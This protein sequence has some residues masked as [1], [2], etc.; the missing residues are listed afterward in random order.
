[1]ARQ[2]SRTVKLTPHEL[3]IKDTRPTFLLLIK[4][5]LTEIEVQKI[6]IRLL[7]L[8]EPLQQLR[9]EQMHFDILRQARHVFR[10][11]D[12]FVLDD[13]E[14]AEGFAV[15]PVGAQRGVGGR[16]GAALTDLA[17][18]RLRVE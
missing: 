11:N 15:G 10:H 4:P 7:I 13:F 2:R 6:Q 3:N 14:R 1:M 18:V 9:I 17:E 8:D 16:E 5:Q 12:V